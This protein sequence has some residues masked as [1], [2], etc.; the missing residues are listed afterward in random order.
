MPPVM[1]PLLAF[2]TCSIVSTATGTSSG[3]IAAVAPILLPLVFAI[4]CK[5][6]LMC[7]AMVSGAYFGDNLAPIS[8]TTIAS[9]LTQEVSMIKVVR[10]RIKYSVI[11]AV[12][13]AILFWIMRAR[14]TVLA[15]A[16]MMQ[17]D[18]AFAKNLVFLALPI[19]VVVL[20]VRG[21]NL[22]T[23]LLLAD[24]LGAAMLLAMGIVNLEGMVSG[25][26]IVAS[27]IDGMAG[28]TG[29][30]DSVVERVK[31]RAK[32]PRSAEIISGLFTELLVFV[33]GSPS[34]SVVIA[35]PMAR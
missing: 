14:T 25:T 5:T 6:E 31:F 8:D 3:T 11:C 18:P 29:F 9:A 23:S 2:I 26:G 24:I 7:G 10:S 27:G 33:T 35:G 28:A 32:T 16:A 12:I 30:L 15:N 13:A 17:G 19:L 1:L 4:G 22:L 34:A 20:M 21:A